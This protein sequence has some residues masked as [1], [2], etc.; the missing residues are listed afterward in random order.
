MNKPRSRKLNNVP[1]IFPSGCTGN[2]IL[3][4]SLFLAGL[5]EAQSVST[6]KGGCRVLVEGSIIGFNS[7]SGSNPLT[8]RVLNK[9][10]SIIQYIF[11]SNKK[12]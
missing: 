2:T 5:S 6:D 7:L 8:N 9:K 1:S 11:L 4:A 12:Y 10:K 3:S